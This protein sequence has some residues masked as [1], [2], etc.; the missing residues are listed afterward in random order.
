M[1]SQEAGIMLDYRHYFT[2]LSL[3]LCSGTLLSLTPYK[4]PQSNLY[5]AWINAEFHITG[6]AS[7]L[8]GF[9][10]DSN[11][12]ITYNEQG[13]SRRSLAWSLMEDP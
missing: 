4:G 9:S 13:V 10:E 8:A 3:H 6:N 11:G 5:Q 1:T 7:Y 2:F 12:V